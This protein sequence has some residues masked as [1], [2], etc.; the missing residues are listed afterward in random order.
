MSKYLSKSVPQPWLADP[1]IKDP[2][3]QVPSYSSP[4]ITS[5]LYS[6]NV[7]TLPYM[8]PRYSKTVVEE[9]PILREIHN[10][11]LHQLIDSKEEQINNLLRM[12]QQGVQDKM[13]FP[14]VYDNFREHYNAFIKSINALINYDFHGLTPAQYGNGLALLMTEYTLRS[15][16]LG[17]YIDDMINI[18]KFREYCK[19]SKTC[20]SPCSL[21]GVCDYPYDDKSLNNYFESIFK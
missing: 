8:T 12:I 19:K 17:N 2:I 15:R 9:S 5:P 1:E 20:T 4:I 16:D 7:R 11:F 13:L 10:S 6:E 3:Y 18:P 21:N 14:Y